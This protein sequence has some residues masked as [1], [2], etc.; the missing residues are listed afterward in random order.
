MHPAD[1]YQDIREAVRD[2]CGEFSAE[3]FRKIDEERGYPE[4]FVDA[5]TKAGWLAALIPQE[6]GGSGLGLTEASVIMEE[7]NRAG[8]NSG[9]C[10]GQM[11][12][13][14]TLLRH[15]S[16]E[17]KQRYLPKF[18]SGE[19]RLQSMGVTEPTTGT[20]TTKIKTTAVR[21]GD[22]YV[23]NGQKVWISRVQHSD[24]MILLART[25]PLSDVKKKS[26]GMS[27]FIVDLHHAIGNGMTVRPIPNMVNHETNELFF[28]NLEIP[29]ENLIGEEGRGFKY[30]LDGLNAERTLIAAECIG[31]GYWFVD[32]VSQYVKDR[33]V[34]GRPIGQNQGVQF[35]IAR[36][37]VN[38]EAAS[39]MRF[40]AARR[41]DAHEPCGAQ[42]NMAKLLA[43]DASWEA[44]N[45]CL[46]FHGGFGFA[47]EYDVERK[48]RET[49]LYQ[50]A[51]ISTN[52]ILSYVAEHI[53]GLPRSF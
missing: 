13:M 37:F 52:L 21:K 49:R 4:A 23:I 34:F 32:K 28:D 26:E 45:A 40:E 31:D 22:R 41:F 2:L 6:Y 46:Q 16:A 27:I 24:L 50:V 53:L 1:A 20:D 9:A 36:S 29:T 35:P 39:L 10:H 33:V 38:V 18:A 47:C 42:A 12:N 7:I 51:P 30:I 25:T 19:L 5:L 3:Y 48:F 44:A 17:Q 11:Y 14:G 8:G 15:G 43:A